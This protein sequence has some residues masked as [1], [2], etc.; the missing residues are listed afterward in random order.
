MVHPQVKAVGMYNVHYYPS[1]HCIHTVFT[2]E[3]VHVH[4]LA[5]YVTVA[6]VSLK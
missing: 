5:D 2:I 6:A 3:H 1:Y 4:I